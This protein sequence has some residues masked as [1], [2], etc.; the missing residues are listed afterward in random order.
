MSEVEI[1]RDVSLLRQRRWITR[2]ITIREE[3]NR[4]VRCPS[5]RASNEGEIYTLEA[6]AASLQRLEE[7]DENK[8]PA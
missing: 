7:L 1:R 3:L 6:I 5:R 4:S 2:E 8:K